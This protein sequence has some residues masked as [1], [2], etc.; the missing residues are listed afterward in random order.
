VVGG[1]VKGAVVIFVPRAPVP[2]ESQRL[3]GGTVVR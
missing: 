3:T 1:K 2:Q